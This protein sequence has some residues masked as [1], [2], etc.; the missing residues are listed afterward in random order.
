MVV[1]DLTRSWRRFGPVIEAEV[2]AQV[3]PGGCIPAVVPAHEDGM[4]PAARHD[5][6]GAAEALRRGVGQ[7]FQAADK[8][9]STRITAC[10]PSRLSC[11]S[12]AKPFSAAFAKPEIY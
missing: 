8:R 2:Q 4:A 7:S 1:G 3:L 6:A 10:F 5:R 11:S 12:A 9:R